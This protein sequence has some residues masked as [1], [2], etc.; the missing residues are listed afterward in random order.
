MNSKYIYVYQ[1]RMKTNT[2]NP[3]YIYIG[4]I[5]E[6]IPLELFLDMVPSSTADYTIT[7][8]ILARSLANFYCQ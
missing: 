3:L 6:G 8:R 1:E 7:V 5:P 4:L 2:V